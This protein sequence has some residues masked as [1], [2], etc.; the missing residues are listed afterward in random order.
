MAR[1]GHN[2]NPGMYVYWILTTIQPCWTG[3]GASHTGSKGDICGPV[4][5]ALLCFSVHALMPAVVELRG[6]VVKKTEG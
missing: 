2:W 6:Y 3:G 1:S 5:A 4:A